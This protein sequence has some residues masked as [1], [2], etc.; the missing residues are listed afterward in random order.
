MLVWL[1]N[2]K[3]LTKILSFHLNQ[4]ILVWSKLKASKVAYFSVYKSNLFQKQSYCLF[5]FPLK[6]PK[7]HGKNIKKY[8]VRRI[9]F[10]H[11]TMKSCVYLALSAQTQLCVQSHIRNGKNAEICRVKNIWIGPEILERQY[12]VHT[13]IQFV[14]EGPTLFQAL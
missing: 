10:S 13:L 4:N 8:S 11:L 5:Y 12:K 9:I 6:L 14:H 7:K 1:N 2:F 3:S